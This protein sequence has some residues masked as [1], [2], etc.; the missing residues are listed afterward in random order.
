M[1]KTDGRKK[2]RGRT[3]L[4]VP[5]ERDLY[6]LSALKEGY[7]YAEIGRVYKLSR[8][9]VF[10]IKMRWPNFSQDNKKQLKNNLNK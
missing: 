7:S 10:Q 4:K 8:Q 5:S 2:N 9:Y 6:V 3:K 1:K